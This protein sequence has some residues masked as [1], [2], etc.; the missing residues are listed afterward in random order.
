VRSGVPKPPTHLSR[1]AR[2]LWREVVR[3]FALEP[4]HV[5]ILRVSLEAFDRCETA[6]TTIQELGT[7]YVDRFGAPRKHPLVSVEE[8]AR[9][10][11]LR[12][13]RELGLEASV[14]ETRPPRVGGR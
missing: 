10:A 5:A 8:A 14:P 3:E 12:G 9:I 13:M 2:A 4:H 11:F 7:T 1:E 6:R